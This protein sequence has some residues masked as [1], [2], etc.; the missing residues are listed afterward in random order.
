MHMNAIK[1]QMQIYAAFKIEI[2]QKFKT[3]PL[4]L[5]M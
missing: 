4:Y 2:A 3:K 1:Y 5:F